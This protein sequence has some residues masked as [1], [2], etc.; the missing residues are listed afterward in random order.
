MNSSAFFVCFD[1][2]ESVLYI[3]PIEWK[4]RQNNLKITLTLSL[5]KYPHP[6]GNGFSVSIIDYSTIT[7]GIPNENVDGYT[8]NYVLKHFHEKRLVL[9]W[10]WLHTYVICAERC[11]RVCK[12]VCVCRTDAASYGSAPSWTLDKENSTVFSAL[13]DNWDDALTL[14]CY[15]V[16]FLSIR[17]A[18][19]N[20]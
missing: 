14:N 10:K 15:V 6:K 7:H 13:F 4:N 9:S 1:S 2:E 12:C 8:P 5:V 3:S 17:V 19:V 16:Y 20:C 11:V 18:Q